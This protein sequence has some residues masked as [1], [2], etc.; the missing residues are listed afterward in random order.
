LLEFARFLSGID[1]E[2]EKRAERIR[3]KGKKVLDRRA[4]IGKQPVHSQQGGSMVESNDDWLFE[5]LSPTRLQ[6]AMGESLDGILDDQDLLEEAVNLLGKDERDSFKLS[7][8][9]DGILQLHIDDGEETN[10]FSGAFLQENDKVSD[11]HA[12][13]FIGDIKRALSPV[14]H[15]SFDDDD[16][17][18]HSFI[19]DP[20][21]EPLK[22]NDV[23]LQSGTPDDISQNDR[24]LSIGMKGDEIE[25]ESRR[26]NVGRP[27]K[28]R[29]ATVTMPKGMNSPSSAMKTPTN[30]DPWPSAAKY[31]EMFLS[32][33]SFTFF[34]V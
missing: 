4:F 17:D 3:D 2:E 14:K 20:F 10:F 24:G 21:P 22:V 31:R 11:L 32:F 25:V 9:D 18:R 7:N 16:D 13:N 5:P 1:A 23:M 34:L 12:F 29:K 26:T 30:L 6:P 33:V 8:G 27:P 15:I 28:G 19:L